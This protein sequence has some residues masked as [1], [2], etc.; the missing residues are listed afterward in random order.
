MPPV[1]V[2]RADLKPGEILCTYCTAHCCRYFAVPIDTPTTWKDF[3]NIRW[4]LMHGSAAVFVDK[5][6]W[7]L[8]VNAVCKHLQSDNRCGAYDTRPSIC[9][10][11]S[12]TNCE[13]DNS[14]LYDKYFESPE[15]V[16]EYAEA[17]LPPRKRRRTA[18]A[19]LPIL[20]SV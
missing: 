8:I 9:R 1:L 14:F 2:R 19:N 3:D 16:Q 6:V 17:V 7:Y 5:R 4:Y 20:N 18:P 12:T 13:Y 15:Q 11:Y 10:E